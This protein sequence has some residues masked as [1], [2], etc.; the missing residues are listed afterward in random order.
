MDN[1][2]LADVSALRVLIPPPAEQKRIVLKV[3]ALLAR[4]DAARARLAKVQAILKRFR[5][6]VLAAAC[7]GRLTADW[8][9]SHPDIYPSS[10]L[11]T[12]IRQDT[13]ATPAKTTGAD[14]YDIE[15]PESWCWT[16]LD[17]LL[18]DIEAGKN[19]T[20]IERPPIK[21]EVGV[22]KVSA[23]SW[24]EFDELASKTC[25]NPKLVNPKHF[26][27]E[28]DFLFSRANTIELV[29]ACVIASR[30]T[31]TL[32]LSDKIL[33][34]KLLGGVDRW[35]LYWLRSNAG[36][37]QIESLATGNQQS[38]RNIGQERI[39]RIVIVLPPLDE[40]RE[41]VRHVDHFLKLADGIEKRVAMATARAEKLTQS[42]LAKAFRGELVPTEAE[43]ARREGHEYE[44]ASV[45]LERIRAG[46]NGNAQKDSEPKRNGSRGS[47]K[48]P[49]TRATGA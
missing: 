47:V 29:G 34:L 5:Q 39:R 48:A 14:H 23:V 37:D 18:S 1:I 16:T 15:A 12:S 7:S 6:S 43:L 33:R 2:S 26:I 20:C 31:R 17:V 49:V 45:L 9:E 19:F 35:V 13:G 22:V 41:I 8:R 24:G 46:L 28:G 10:A 40:Q 36:R 30:P 44:P 3:E 42:I 4:V 27:K 11:L 38:M 21:G 25:P 32:M